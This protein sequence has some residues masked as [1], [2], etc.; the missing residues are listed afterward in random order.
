MRTISKV[1]NFLNE[2]PKIKWWHILAGLLVCVAF[3]ANSCD[4]QTTA[5]TNNAT[6]ASQK[7]GASPAI[8]NYY[9]YYQLKQIYEARDNPNI[10]MNAYLYSPQTG[11]FTCLGKVAGY[12]VPY[13]TE[14][15]PPTGS[16]SQGSIPE[17]N[18]LYPS[19]N[20]NADWVRIIDANGKQHIAFVEPDL[21]ITDMVYP[22]K[23][24]T[25]SQQ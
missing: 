10:V 23:P 2:P 22:C 16:G 11:Q 3:M 14:W 4:T 5:S 9:E 12:G 15:S 13:G 21:V 8:T 6:T 17:P 18:A 7:W 20:T 1:K 24:L 25:G 19:Q